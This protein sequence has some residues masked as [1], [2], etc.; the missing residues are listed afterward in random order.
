MKRLGSPYGFVNGRGRGFGG[1]C[2]DFLVH[3]ALP[4]NGVQTIHA[5][6]GTP[7][8]L[9]PEIVLKHSFIDGIIKFMSFYRRRPC[10]F[11]FFLVFF[12]LVDCPATVCLIQFQASIAS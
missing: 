10:P 1:I 5:F 12:F 7:R 6:V 3:T 4:N 2:L 9:C 11:F 8:A